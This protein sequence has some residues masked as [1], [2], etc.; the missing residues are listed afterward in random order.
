[1]IIVTVMLSFI[2]RERTT[3]IINSFQLH[4]MHL[5]GVMNKWNVSWRL[6]KAGNIAF[7]LPSHC[8]VNSLSLSDRSGQLA[9]IIYKWRVKK[10]SVAV[11]VFSSFMNPEIFSR[12]RKNIFFF[13]KK[14][15]KLCRMRSQIT[16][17][18]VVFMLFIQE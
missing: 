18:T 1:M 3:I 17:S 6:Y 16:W 7:L 14:D 15:I 13:F 12:R 11:E 4:F 8:S 2:I 5:R 10:K 9:F